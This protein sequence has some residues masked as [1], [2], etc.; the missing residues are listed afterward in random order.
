MS[1]GAAISMAGPSTHLSSSLLS[2]RDVQ[3]CRVAV[4]RGQDTEL[5]GMCGSFRDLL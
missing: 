3:T 1:P 2:L 5:S 4:L